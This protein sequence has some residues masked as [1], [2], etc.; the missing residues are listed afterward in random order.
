MEPNTILTMAASLRNVPCRL[1]KL[2]W[3]IRVSNSKY[4]C[5]FSTESSVQLIQE[6]NYPPAKP[7]YPPG[8][9]SE[10]IPRSIIWKKYEEEQNL[11]KTG[12][13]R[14]RLET[15][16]GTK[17]REMIVVSS[18]DRSPRT[19]E[20]K[21]FITRT[22]IVNSLPDLYTNV[23]VEAEYQTLK[24]YL[25]DAIL[26]EHEYFTR[27]RGKINILHCHQPEYRSRRLMS[28]IVDTMLSVCS[29]NYP[30]LLSAQVDNDVRVE[31]CWKID[32]FKM[33]N[34]K[35]HFGRTWLQ[36]KGTRAKQMRT[37][38]PL[39]E[40]IVSPDMYVQKWMYYN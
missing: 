37:D 13:V 4:A 35:N 14:E 30:H 10:D 27:S 38:L 7:K 25:I 17:D 6:P 40:V 20:Y 19:L 33:A 9:W 32:G 1:S 21:E 29:H 5:P 24:P 31:T 22:K 23:D 15:I 26:F 39:P 36:Y 11:L 34:V 12:D 8:K 3:Q 18:F 16:A 2:F 28:N